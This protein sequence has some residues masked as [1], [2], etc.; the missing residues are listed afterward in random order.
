MVGSD[1][2]MRASLVTLPCSTGTLRS[3][4]IRTRF[5]RRSWSAMRSTFI[6]RSLRC[7]GPR[8]G[9]V[10]HAV[11][12]APLVVVPGTDLDQRAFTDARQRG[13]VGRGS[14]VMVVVDRHELLVG[15]REHALHGAFGRFLDDLVDLVNR[16]SAL[17]DERQ[18][19]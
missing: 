9:G 3:S 17:G 11:A 16:G 18:V 7:L 14:R 15:V 19:D 4:R 6:P 12:E 1:A 8:D 5:P 2:R 13:V 10:Q